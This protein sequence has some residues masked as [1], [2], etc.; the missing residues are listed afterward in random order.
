MKRV[1]DVFG[2][3]EY[4]TRW[5]GSM[6]FSFFKNRNNVQL[7]IAGEEDDKF[8]EEQY[9]AYQN[10]LDKWEDIQLDILGEIYE[11]YMELKE[12]EGY[13]EEDGYPDI[14]GPEDLI[15]MVSLQI[16]HIK[17]PL[18]GSRCVALA[19]DATWDD[20][21]GVGIRLLNEKV[22]RVAGNNIV[23]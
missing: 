11:Y 17:R 7:L 6:E 13:T 19:F 1:D 21:W 8:S 15:D 20:D 18:R 3:L 14:N 2:D 16:I 5:R 23:F 4:D 9:L 12:E 10:L 22:E